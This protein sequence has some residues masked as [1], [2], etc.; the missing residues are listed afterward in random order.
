MRS[1]ELTA[2]HRYLHCVNFE[3]ESAAKAT[4]VVASALGVKQRFY[5]PVAKWLSKQGYRVITFD[6]YGI[7]QSVDKPLKQINSSITDWA[8]LD[9]TTVIDY[10]QSCQNG[11]PLIWLA[12]SLGGQIVAMAHNSDKIDKMVTIASGTGYWL[13]ASQQVRRTAWLLWYFAVPIATPLAG[14]FPGKRLNMVG[15]MPAAAMKEWSRWCRSKDYLFD[16]IT[17][18]QQACYDTF[19]APIHAFNVTDDELLQRSNIE[20]LLSHY[21]NA[22]K[23]LEDLSPNMTQNNRIG[24][25]SFFRS[26][27]KDSLWQEHLLSALQ[28]S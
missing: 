12:H 9:I 8:E 22:D 24:H 2:N 14:Y 27:F 18:E 25:F 16:N 11:E 17:A 6:Y 26:Q 13:K 19:K 1:I 4:I 7:G 3:P 15:D 5:Q 10:A 20:N 28:L 21:P 23:V